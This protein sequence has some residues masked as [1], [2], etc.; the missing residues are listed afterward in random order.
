[1]SAELGGAEQQAAQ[2]AAQLTALVG[3]KSAMALRLAQAA[4][5]MARLRVRLWLDYG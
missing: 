3:A 4:I 2:Q 5:L 1:M